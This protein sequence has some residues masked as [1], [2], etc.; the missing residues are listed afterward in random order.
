MQ[1]LPGTRP[2]EVG[3]YLRGLQQ[4]IVELE[5][6]VKRLGEEI[7]DRER[8]LATSRFECATARTTIAHL[9]SQIEAVSP[10]RWSERA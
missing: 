3:D 8:R 7:A 5:T 2:E 9:Q 4:R 6:E 1:T 10:H